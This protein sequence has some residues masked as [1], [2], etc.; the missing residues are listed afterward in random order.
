MPIAGG[1]PLAVSAI[2]PVPVF[3]LAALLADDGVCVDWIA[4][5]FG[6]YVAVAGMDAV[7]VGMG[8]VAVL[9]RVDVEVV[10]A[11]GGESAAPDETVLAGVVLDMVTAF[12]LLD[13]AAWFSLADVTCTSPADRHSMKV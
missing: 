12:C 11:A 2:D 13:L 10:P 1:V 5:A 7:S 4:A 6:M 8:V 3:T 9:V